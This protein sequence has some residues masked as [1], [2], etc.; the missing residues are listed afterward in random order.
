M[1][2]KCFYH[3]GDDDGKSSGAIVKAKYPECEL[4]PINYG[5]PFPFDKISPKDTVFVVDYCLEPV[6]EMVKL[7]KSC[8]LIW[9]DHHKSSIEHVRNAGINPD[10]I[11][12][13]GRSGC[14]LTWEFL[15]HGK[16]MPLAIYLIGRYD[17]WDHSDPRTLPFMYGMR[18]EDTRP[19]NDA[20]WENLLWD[21][22]SVLENILSNGNITFPYQV[23]EDERLAKGRSFETNFDGYRAIVMNM[24]GGSSLAFNSVYDPEK[25]DIMIAFLYNAGTISVSI[26]STKD[27]VDASKI[28]SKY[29]GGG[30]A[31][32]SGFKFDDAQEF[33]KLISVK[34]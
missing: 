8:E 4:F 34:K 16:R 25:H 18:M 22:P 21:E 7:N 3:S 32:A 9:I 11:R 2:Y 30:H 1:G 12:T 24:G 6:S 20:L 31:A 23:K 27:N 5:E 14:E 33:F 15:F 29:N 28:A 26:Y 19:T 13:I 17:V 10:G